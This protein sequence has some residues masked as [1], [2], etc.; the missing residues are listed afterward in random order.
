MMQEIP[1]SEKPDRKSGLTA[2]AGTARIGQR[3]RGTTRSAVLPTGPCPFDPPPE[4][5]RER[6]QP[7]GATTHS[8]GP[9]NP[10]GYE[11]MLCHFDSKSTR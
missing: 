7:N 2:V 10:F 1:F 11:R 5:D 6:S 9:A 4:I 3:S 8:V